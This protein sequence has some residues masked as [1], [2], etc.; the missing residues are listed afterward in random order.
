M[1]VTM[2]NPEKMAHCQAQH[3]KN[4]YILTKKDNCSQTKIPRPLILFFLGRL[5]QSN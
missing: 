4:I 5:S 3:K 1:D 2:G